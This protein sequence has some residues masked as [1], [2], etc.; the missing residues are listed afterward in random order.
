VHRVEA[1]GGHELAVREQVPVG[2][3]GRVGMGG[4]RTAATGR[5]EAQRGTTSFA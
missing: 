5:E 3:H 4:R 2:E 1:A